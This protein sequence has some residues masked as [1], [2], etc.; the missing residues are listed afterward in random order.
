[1]RKNEPSLDHS[2]GGGAREGLL[3]HSLIAQTVMLSR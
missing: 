3:A 2:G 1:M